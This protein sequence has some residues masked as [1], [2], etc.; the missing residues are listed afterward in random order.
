MNEYSGHLVV[1]DE[2]RMSY[3]QEQSSLRFENY[4]SLIL[5]LIAIYGRVLLVDLDAGPRQLQ[6][7][8]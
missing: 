1:T 4:S 6:H 7:L 8:Y 3:F 5:L 2:I